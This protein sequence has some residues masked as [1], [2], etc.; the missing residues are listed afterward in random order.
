M[1]TRKAGEAD[2]DAVLAL[3]R[4]LRPHDPPLAR[5][6]PPGSG[7]ASATARSHWLS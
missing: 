6:M 7:P 1:I 5:E 4:E 2:M 3:Y